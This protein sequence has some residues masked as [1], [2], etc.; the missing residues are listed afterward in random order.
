MKDGGEFRLEGEFGEGGSR[1]EGEPVQQHA[2]PRD[3]ESASPERDG[4]RQ[5]QPARRTHR[6]EFAPRKRR[7]PIQQSAAGAQ[8][9]QFDEGVQFAGQGVGRQFVGLGHLLPQ[10][11]AVEGGF[12]ARRTVGGMGS[13]DPGPFELGDPFGRIMEDLGEDSLVVLAEPGRSPPHAPGSG[14]ESGA[15]RPPS[16]VRP[17]GPPIRGTCRAPRSE[18]RARCPGCP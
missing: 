18:D 11:Q 6:L 4:S 2:G 7:L 16:R 8:F 10:L 12:P 9:M 17:P 14:G 1:A 13:D 15:T 3:R 5:S